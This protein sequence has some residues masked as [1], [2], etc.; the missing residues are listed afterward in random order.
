MSGNQGDRPGLAMWLTAAGLLLL[1]ANLRPLF[2][3]I[4]V[5]LPELTQ[6]LGLNNAQAGYLTTLPVLCMGL[7]AP[8]APRLAQRIGIERTLFV[9]LICIVLGTGVRGSGSVTGL[10]VGTALAGAGI[11]LGNVLLPSLVKRDYARQAALMTG[12]YTMSLVGGAAL[13]AAAT[14]P[15]VH[16]LGLDWA[17]G[18]AL[19]AVPAVLALLAW[20][21]IALRGEGH[22]SGRRRTRPVRGLHRDGLA[23]AVTVF[24]GL[25]SALGY[26][27][28]GWMAPILQDRGMSGTEAG[29]VTSISIFTQVGSCLLV[30]MLASR[31][32]DQR[33]LAVVLTLITTLSLVGMTAGPLPLVWPLAFIQ[34]IGQG[35]M[36]A[37]ALMLIVLR[38]PDSDVAAHLSGMS[39]TSGYVLA[40]LGPLLIGLLHEWTGSFHAASALMAALG[41]IS[42]VAGWLAGRNALVRAQVVE[43]AHTRDT[44]GT[45]PG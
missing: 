45:S 44:S 2:S 28:M 34:G 27:V 24:M 29:L 9:V 26:S 25:Q 18:L 41:T 7:F 38:S 40:C 20:A 13:G 33:M 31:F 42:G 35:G 6:G 23:W 4:S 3:S 43:P 15:L 11:A 22:S 36:F 39:Q 14:L 19:W 16:G 30:P 37:L 8:L 12:L 5:L 1:A 17:G 21:P 32:R 10:F